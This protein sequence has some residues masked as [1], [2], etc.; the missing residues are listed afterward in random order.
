MKG[1]RL[2]Q[3]KDGSVR[4]LSAMNDRN[5]IGFLAFSDGTK[6]RVPVGPLGETQFEIERQVRTLQAA[7]GTGL[8]DAIAEAIKMVDDAPGDPEAIRGVVVL[9]DGEANAGKTNL[10][11]LVRLTG[12]SEAAVPTFRG[13]A[14]DRVATDANGAQVPVKDLIGVALAS[15]TRHPVHVFFVGVGEADVQVGRL[16]AEATGSSYQTSTEAGLAA[17]LERLGR[18]F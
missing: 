10:S 4:L 3:A 16:L 9:T 17:A 5:S 7:G 8:Y 12:R 6:A 15:P 11:D 13:W 18:Y 2:E 14:D 1:Q